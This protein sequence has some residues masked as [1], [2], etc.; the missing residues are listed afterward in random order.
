MAV[1]FQAQQQMEK[2]AYSLE[3][4]QTYESVSPLEIHFLSIYP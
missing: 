1:N 2:A 4:I 3:P